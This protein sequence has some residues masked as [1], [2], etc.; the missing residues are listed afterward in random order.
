MKKLSLLCLAMLPCFASEGPDTDAEDVSPSIKRLKRLSINMTPKPI[1]DP[2]ELPA[3]PSVKHRESHPNVFPRKRSLKEETVRPEPAMA[4]TGGSIPVIDP[5]TEVSPAT[6]VKKRPPLER[7]PG[8]PD[9]Y[10]HARDK[11]ANMIPPRPLAPKEDDSSTQVVAL[12]FQQP[13]SERPPHPQE[14]DSSYQVVVKTYEGHFRDY[15]QPY[16]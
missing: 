9:L 13:I 3:V 10:A 6:Y 2:D 4:F 7:S 12:P 15:D 5:T 8:C 11:L 1:G 14:E 16:I